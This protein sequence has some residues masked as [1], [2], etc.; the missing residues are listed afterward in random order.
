LQ[1]ILLHLANELIEEIIAR[2]V[3]A[4]E[5]TIMVVDDNFILRQGLQLLLEADGYRVETAPNGLEALD[6]M[7]AHAPDLIL[8]DVAMP[9]M[10]GYSFF[11]E[12][13]ERPEWVTIPFIFLTA[14]GDRQEMFNG[15]GLGAEDYLVKPVS[16][17]ELILTV[18]S[19]LARSQQILLA[20]LQTAYQSSLI[21]LSNAIELRDEYTRGHVE[22]VMDYS[23][24]I[25]HSMGW[26]NGR[27]QPLR[28]GSILH[29]IGKIHIREAVLHK[30]GPLDQEE[31]LEMR[32]HPIIGAELIKNI[33]YLEAAMPIVR[34]HHERWDG[35]GY[36]DGLKGEAIPELARLVAVADSLDAMTYTRV[37]QAALSPERAYQEIIRNSGTAYDPLIVE[38]FTSVWPAIRLRMHNPPPASSFIL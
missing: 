38:A 31:W 21:M 12:V 35:N 5:A 11:E 22:R 15:K 16:R 3:M 25:A 6:K 7:V 24:I 10:D 34:H 26:T 33:E 29:D 27:L 1:Q 28:L 17:H 30:P 13:R 14:H 37:Y 36:P 20:Q 32:Q 18:R 23:L 8:S 2:H 4:N 9:G 19:R